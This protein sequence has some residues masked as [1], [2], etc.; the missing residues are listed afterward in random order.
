M[1]KIF[2][3]LL[4]I[5]A[6]IY[7]AICTFLYFYQ[8]RIIFA[9]QKLKSTYHFDFDRPF[10]EM[11]IETQDGTKLNGLLFPSDSSKGLIFHLHGNA[12]SL[13]SW[14][15]VAKVYNDMGY[16]IFMFD[17]RGY[18]KSEGK[19]TSESQLFRD[20]QTVYDSLKNAYPEERITMIGYSIG[21]GIAAWLA[22]NNH[23]HQL[24]LEVPYANL[25]NIMHD[26]YPLIP[27]FILKYKFETDKYLQQSKAP[28]TIFHGTD[29]RV[30]DYRN[31]L[32]LQKG[33]KA[34]DTLILLKNQGHN[35]I[36]D[37]PKYRQLLPKIL[38]N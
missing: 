35:G 18:G 32:E 33:F 11:A 31:S 38:A 19:I 14:G 21:T 24:I 5:I 3:R 26:R 17:Y 36:S 20:V 28:L 15:K 10:R 4:L 23:P 6:V 22:A 7:V 1:K 27:A 2:L 12:G 34:A 30:I 8:E 16:D 25:S 29:D 9:P 13:K 37:N